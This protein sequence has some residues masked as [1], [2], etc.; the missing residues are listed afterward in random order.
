[1]ETYLNKKTKQDEKR[2]ES[3]ISKNEKRADSS[4]KK[5]CFEIEKGK[6]KIKKIKE[7]TE[8]EKEVSKINNPYG[9]SNFN[10]I[11]DINEQ[12]DTN[13]IIQ[14]SLDNIDKEKMISLSSCK[15]LKSF[16]QNKNNKFLLI[17]SSVNS[18]EHKKNRLNYNKIHSFDNYMS[19]ECEINNFCIDSKYHFPNNS[20]S[21][22][23]EI[24]RIITRPFRIFHYHKPNVRSY[25][26][27]VVKFFGN[28]GSG[29]SIMLRMILCNYNQF[30]GDF[31]PFC[32]FN[33]K[34]LNELYKNNHYDEIKD[35]INNEC[36][37][38]FH[39]LTKF[40]SFIQKINF[41]HNN[42][43]E[44]I[45][46]IIE[47][48]LIEYQDNY[49]LFIIDNFSYCYD[50]D[51]IVDQLEKKCFEYKRFNLYLIFDIKC[52]KDQKTFINL[53]APNNRIYDENDI[54]EKKIYFYHQN[55]KSFKLI[56]N[57]LI[58]DNIA[59]PENYEKYF[60]DNSSYFFSFH[61]NK[62]LNF[63][64]FVERQKLEIIF[65]IN[66]FYECISNNKE[67]IN[68]IYYFIKRK[69]VDF[70]YDYFNLLPGNYINFT[71][72]LL[73]DKTYKYSIDFSFPL[74]KECFEDIIKK[75]FFIN[76]R[77]EE[78]INLEKGPMEIN[79]DIYMKDWIKK[80]RVLFGIN[81]TDIEIID[82]ED[83]ILENNKFD[84]T[85]KQM[86]KKKD[87]IQSI[88]QNLKLV[89]FKEKYLKKKL[90]YKKLIIIYQK[91]S[92]KT[93]D[94]LIIGFN[95]SIRKFILNSIQIKLSDSYYITKEI[96]E[97]IP[98]E[99]EYIREKYSYLLDIEIENNYS[100]YTYLSLF[101]NKKVFA[102]KNIDKFIFYSKDKDILVDKEGNEIKEIPL[103]DGAK[104]LSFKRNFYNIY[105]EFL[106][107]QYNN[108]LILVEKKETHFNKIYKLQNNEAIYFL[109]GNKTM[110][111]WK[112]QDKK[113][114]IETDIDDNLK[115]YSNKLFSIQ[116]NIKF[117]EGINK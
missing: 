66:Q 25:V 79:F 107:M 37:S 113:G 34:L 90:K 48:Y 8:F 2:S 44:L 67:I 19:K 63:D 20:I 6:G 53:Y 114:S 97:K 106:S 77:D 98:L 105:E 12:N 92:G 64:E 82:N 87:I 22:F 7:Y 96:K 55:L 49:P 52:Q 50:E 47:K 116:E 31:T 69:N 62:K 94:F 42:V 9:I 102:E 23:Y 33:I 51:N 57:Y 32:F 39:K 93:T 35:I 46:Q 21:K 76:I 15:D 45:Q 17:F 60:G 61:K 58:K 80:K 104:I 27:S 54:E 89:N 70:S 88:N 72:E 108:Q 10:E 91:F 38:L 40:E 36:L 111:K 99:M 103:M 109:E 13:E 85:V 59:I 74:I 110:F 3:P 29:K 26:E 14:F 56:K 75:K 117:I 43:F 16:Y 5:C 73:E 68:N 18:E 101:E 86:N 78:F 112:Y 83:D 24:D 1:M 100:Y 71:K 81:E 115:E 41:I 95:E 4:E 28:K 65:E 11:I 30:D 84:I